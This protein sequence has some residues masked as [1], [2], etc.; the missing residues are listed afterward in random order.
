MLNCVVN[1]LLGAEDGL[2]DGHPLAN[3][4][5]AVRVVAL[6]ERGDDMHLPGGRRHPAEPVQRADEVVGTHKH[7]YLDRF[8]P[9]DVVKLA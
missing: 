5:L 9:F 1:G 2:R 7:D 3:V 4:G 6:V 8:A